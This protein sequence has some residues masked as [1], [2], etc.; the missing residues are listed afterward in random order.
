[1][2]ITA[3]AAHAAFFGFFTAWL[4]ERKRYGAATWFAL[5]LLLG[6]VAPLLLFLQPDRALPDHASLPPAR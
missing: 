2:D 4:A 1:M 3:I 5:G 6:A